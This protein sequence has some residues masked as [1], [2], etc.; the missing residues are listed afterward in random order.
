MTKDTNEN[1]HAQQQEDGEGALVSSSA[2]G[3]SPR[4]R[5]KTAAANVDVMEKVSYVS[6]VSVVS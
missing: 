4:K 2:V 1:D 5:S 3:E 6:S